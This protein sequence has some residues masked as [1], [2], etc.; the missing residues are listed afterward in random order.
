MMHGRATL[1]FLLLTLAVPAALAGQ[2]VRGRVLDAATGDSVPGARVVLQTEAGRYAGQAVA[3]P[4]G[5][6]VVA[7]RQA[8]PH[9]LEVSHAGF[10]TTLTDVFTIEPRQ[11]VEVDVRLST[12]VIALDPLTIT[13]RRRDPRHEPTHEG[14]YT[15]YLLLPKI[16]NARA[17]SRNDGEMINARHV[18]DVLTWLPPRYCM[19]VYWNGHLQE[20]PDGAH[21][22]LETPAIDLEGIEFY[23][24]LIYAPQT[25]RDVP[26]YLALC[27]RHS[28]IALWTRTGYFGDPPEPGP[29]TSRLA[30]ATGLYHLGG[31]AAPGLGHGVEAALHW[32][33]TGHFAMGL[34]ARRST[35][36]LPAEVTQAQLPEP[37]QWPYT[38]PPGRRP[39]TLWTAGLESR[40]LLPRRGPAWPVLAA[41]AQL[42]RRAFTLQSRSHDGFDVAIDSWGAALGVTAGAEMLVGGR[43]ALHAAVAH[44]RYFFGPY[45]E[46]ERRYNPTSAQWRG[47]AL[48][49]GIG[50]ALER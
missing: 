3:G 13:A 26:G 37:G 9:R 16:G 28:V 1:A 20:S 10:T 35:H 23:R 42:A 25:M 43:F 17:I 45:G 21:M 30:V 38:Q 47:T 36:T 11:E 39:L 19:A 46:I 27:P 34:L 31:R 48:R 41:R 49:I 4:D 8:G 29:S 44:D 2:S 33:V 15:R 32:P 14:F 22:R 12:H 7:A 50:Y 24:H 5:I 18:G 40:L 6:F